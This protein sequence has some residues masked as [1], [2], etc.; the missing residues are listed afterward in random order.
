[1]SEAAQGMH[2]DS[3]G[4][5][6][7]AMRPPATMGDAAHPGV[8]T[9]DVAEAPLP[10]P[11]GGA[12][13]GFPA[14]WRT[15][16]AA[17]DR[18]V[19]ALLGRYD[20]PRAVARAL[21]DMRAELSRKGPRLDASADGAVAGVP[22]RWQDYASALALPEA[23]VLGE[24]DTPLVED[25]FQA[26]HAA[27]LPQRHVD[28]VMRWFF[29][30]RESQEISRLNADEAAYEETAEALRAAW[31]SAQFRRNINAIG[32]ALRPIFQ[33]HGQDLFDRVL[34]ARLPD[35]ARLGDHAGVTQALVDV[36][37]ALN[38]ATRATP[39]DPTA[40]M[41]SLTA[42][43]AEIEAIMAGPDAG[44]AYWANEALQQE[45]R[46]LLAAENR[47]RRRVA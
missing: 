3:G 29:A 22:A 8:V 19:E 30:Y 7:D 26:A 14:D 18:D 45:Y 44:S 24:A 34:L 27:Q 41:T 43:R 2:D 33:A 17:G 15:R 10:V 1:M 13:A 38:P 23:M 36:A 42:R 11:T 9:A 6:G 46:G 31:G 47:L 4:A 39:A 20:S 12:E 16:A 5:D 37:L 35:G 32:N 28:A 21:K 40:A 25:F